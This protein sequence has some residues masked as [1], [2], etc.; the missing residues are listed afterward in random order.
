RAPAAALAAAALS[1]LLAREASLAAVA[2]G[3]SDPYSPWARGDGWRLNANS[4][5]D[6]VFRD[7]VEET[8]VKATFQRTAGSQPNHGRGKAWLLELDGGTVVAAGRMAPD[9]TLA[10]MLDGVARRVGVLAHGSEIAVALDG[11]SWRLVEIDPFAARAGDDPAA[12]RLTAPM[13][14]R[15]AR[16]LVE[17]GSKVRRGQP[18]MII[19]AMKMEHTITAPGDGIVERVRFAAGDLV[20]DGTELI[21]LAASGND[22]A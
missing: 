21:T 19:E 7:E 5:Q 9:G 10:L 14:G 2:P 13:P 8:V 3:S 11:E 20:E 16:V 4:H 17:V 1:R 15:V 18:L 12:G 6:L 22:G